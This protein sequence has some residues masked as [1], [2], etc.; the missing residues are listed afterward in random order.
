MTRFE[1]GVYNQQVRDL[2]R[3]GQS[4]QNL[5]DDWAERHIIEVKANDKDAAMARI[6]ARYPEHSGFVVSDVLQLD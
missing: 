1:V 4:H 2:V 6:R 3:N 5:T